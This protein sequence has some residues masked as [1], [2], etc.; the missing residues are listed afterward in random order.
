MSAIAA[1]CFSFA[2]IIRGGVSADGIRYEEPALRR[3]CSLLPSLQLEARGLLLHVL[4]RVPLQK[5]QLSLS[6]VQAL[7]L[8]LSLPP[9]ALHME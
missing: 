2:A 1:A 6:H 7:P 4:N 8:L 5:R 3:E 9:S